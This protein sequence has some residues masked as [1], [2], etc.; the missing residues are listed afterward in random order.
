MAAGEAATT[1][2]EA[3]VEEVPSSRTHPSS[4]APFFTASEVVFNKIQDDPSGN[5][6]PPA[7]IKT[8]VAFE[9]LSQC[10]VTSVARACLGSR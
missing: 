1:A 10:F 9:Y 8:K 7:D 3:S 6:H 4:R 5:L 2:S